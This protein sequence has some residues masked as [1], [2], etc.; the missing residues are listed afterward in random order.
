MYMQSLQYI[1]VCNRITDIPEIRANYTREGIMHFE[2]WRSL[3][4]ALN[5]K[6]NGNF[7]SLFSLNFFLKLP[8]I[9]FKTYYP[10][11]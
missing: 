7:F 6:V 8:C 1:V 4:Y 5:L 10:K 11:K 2:Q 9:S 3:A